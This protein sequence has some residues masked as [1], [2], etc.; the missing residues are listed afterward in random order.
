MNKHHSASFSYH[1]TFDRIVCF[2]DFLGMKTL[3]DASHK[4]HASH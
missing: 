3:Y 2:D 4:K 1:F